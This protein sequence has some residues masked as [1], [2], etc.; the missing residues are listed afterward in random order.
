MCLVA[1][2][3]DGVVCSGSRC[4]SLL[5]VSHSG[6]L[7]LCPRNK[8]SLSPSQHF[9][10]VAP[11][12]LSNDN[13]HSNLNQLIWGPPGCFRAR[14]RCLLP[15]GGGGVGGRLCPWKE[16]GKLLMH[17]YCIFVSMCKP[18][19]GLFDHIQRRFEVRVSG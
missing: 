12:N 6:S 13:Q 17:M 10:F 2:A 4:R 8:F 14:T 19:G 11:A 15:L 9:F 7:E 16:K 5:V 1:V 3:L 18:A